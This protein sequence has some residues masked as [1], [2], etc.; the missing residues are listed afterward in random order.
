[1]Y[2]NILY[3]NA[4]VFTVYNIGY[5]NDT[6]EAAMASGSHLGYVLLEF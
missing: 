1:M 5:D 4:K 6:I 2:G 3:G